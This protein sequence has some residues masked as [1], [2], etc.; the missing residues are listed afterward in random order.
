MMLIIPWKI[1]LKK[2]DV[3]VKEKTEYIDRVIRDTFEIE[4]P[5]PKIITLT[6]I[7]T[8]Q[9]NESIFAEIPIETKQ[10]EDTI[11]ND[12]ANIHYKAFLSGY[13]VSLDNLHI[14]VSMKTKDAVKTQIIR[15]KQKFNFGLVG[16]FGYG[17]FQKKCDA[18]IGVG[19]SYN[20]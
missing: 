18:F 2:N 8:F 4:K 19:I 20:F 6:K 12:S 3:I 16:G 17:V 5:V 14:D 1:A 13:K 11:Y 7:D 15:E 10:Y 9:V